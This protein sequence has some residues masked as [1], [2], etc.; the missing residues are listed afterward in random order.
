M[1]AGGWD[2]IAPLFSYEIHRCFGE[3]RGNGK[4]IS[5]VVEITFW[6]WDGA[7]ATY[8]VLQ[9]ETSLQSRN[10]PFRHAYLLG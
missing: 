4:K 6:Y 7:G 5:G 1:D 8:F 2:S 9:Q 10:R 3:N